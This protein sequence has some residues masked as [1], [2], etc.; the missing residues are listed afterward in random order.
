[1]SS[2]PIVALC[3]AA[4]F[5]A[6]C[7]SNSSERTAASP[8]APSV[9]AIPGEVE[10]GVVRGTV[11]NFPA[12]ADG[13]QFRTELE[14]KYIAMGRRPA[15]VFVDMEGEA[16]WVGEYYRYRVNGCDHDTATQ[17]VMAQVDGAA[18]GPICSL[19]AFPETAV[20]PPRDHVVDF[21]RQLGTKYQSM[22]RSAQSAVDADGAA[23][24]LG[25]YYRYRT[26]GCDH[27]TAS[28]KVMA[29]VDGAAAP[30][31]CISACAYFVETPKTIPGN[32]GN[33]TADLRRTS[34]TCD[35]IAVTDTPWIT[36]NRPFTGTDR[37]VLS[38]S[39]SANTGAPRS[40]TIQFVYPGGISYLTLH[41]GAPAY[42][43][44]FQF[45]DPATSTSPVTECAI[46]GTSTICTLTAGTASLPASMASFDWKVEYAYGGTK[47]RTQVGPLPTFSFTESCGVSPAEG[48]PIPISVTLK[49]TDSAGNS[50]TVF[51]GQGTQPPLQL[52]VFSC[53]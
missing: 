45:F 24:W 17:R 19:L 20:Y 36:I 51:S 22:G 6:A 42:V 41:Q 50:A 2:R 30:P 34:G 12:R 44:A 52:R 7:S 47:T 33:F 8:T 31:S 3:A 26:S 39:V 4:L 38:Y 35:W 18:P 29:Q 49:A 21:R 1:M 37:T 15:Q 25:E 16:T 5:A 9:A 10:G 27:A 43:L 53:S 46:R 11:V 48:A 40:G 28:Q 23:I 13:V 14:N 32:G